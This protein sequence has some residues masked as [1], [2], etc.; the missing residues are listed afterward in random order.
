[1]SVDNEMARVGRII[2][3]DQG[4]EVRV[5]GVQAYATPGV[6][7]IPNVDHFARLGFRNAHR[8]LHGMLDHECGHASD[9]DFQAVASWRMKR[10][11]NPALDTLANLVEDGYVER[12]QGDRYAGSCANIRLMNEWLYAEDVAG[13]TL[14]ERVAKSKD[15]LT[16]VLSAIGTILTPYGHREIEFFETLNPAVGAVLRR[17]E[18]ELREAQ[19]I[20]VTKATA[21]NIAL[22]ERIYAKL[23]VPPP[24]APEPKPEPK[25]EP[26]KG[27]RKERKEPG[28]SAEGEESGAPGESGDG[29]ER[30][31]GDDAGEAPGAGAEKTKSAKPGA[32][33]DNVVM[34]V[35]RWTNATGAPMSASD[36]VNV[37]VRRVFEQ[38]SDVRPYAIFSHEFDIERDFGAEDQAEH[39]KAYE[40]AR[41]EAREVSDALTRSFEVA[42]RASQDIVRASG[43]DEGEVD[44][45]LLAEFSVG[46]VPADQ[47]YTQTVVGDGADTAVEILV[48]CSGSMMGT[49]AA[50]A[51]QAAIAMHEALL[52][53]QIP[54]E[55]T[56][57]TTI[58]SSHVGHHAWAHGRTDEYNR[59]F[60][61]LRDALSEAE[62]RGTDPTLF[63][64]E[65]V[66]RFYAGSLRSAELM[67]PFHAIFKSWDSD[68]A[69]SLMRIDGLAQNLD[70]EAVLWAAQRL[71]RRPEKRKVL[72]V[73]SDGQPAGSRD[74]AQGAA[75]LEESIA[76]IIAAGIETYGIGIQSE[77]VRQY[78]PL[79]WK[80]DKAESLI[81]IAMT[82]LTEVLT[83]NR[84][85]R[86]HVA[87]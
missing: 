33:P 49:K 5:R 15:I 45:D 76:R 69:R 8:M 40:S 9:T 37:L 55:L 34:D 48:D 56:G 67:T 32:P 13:G 12:L 38:P 66:G 22:A 83:Q 68:D 1:M 47:I 70:G 24:P 17:I 35:E 64:R 51:K 46:A 18:P 87:L 63:A 57:F 29:A 79:W 74:N 39:S 26:G 42:L 16:S 82:G 84:Q 30:G 44:A 86:R 62:S 43:H 53:C 58:E 41:T 19:A 65:V 21:Q 72:F 81:D 11:P 6:V 80:A 78:Y 60:A 3:A 4:L 77:A 27:P 73:L 14:A 31:D 54:H 2:A 61:T 20:R 7:T 75:Y 28:E 25:P 52:T 23:A 36:L 10:R 59:T 71:A 85:E 50:L